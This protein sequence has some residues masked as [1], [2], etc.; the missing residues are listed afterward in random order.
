VEAS[1]IGMLNALTASAKRPFIQNAA[2]SNC[3]PITTNAGTSMNVW[4]GVRPIA[5]AV[6][7]VAKNF[8]LCANPVH[9]MLI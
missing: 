5:H 2:E 9:V 4:C 1:N 8:T 3:E 6:D 7:P